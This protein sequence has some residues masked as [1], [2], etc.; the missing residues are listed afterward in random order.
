MLSLDNQVALVT[1]GGQGLGKEICKVLA[2]AGARV[3]VADIK[4][5]PAKKLA[6]ELNSSGKKAKAV[7]L[8]VSN[9]DNIKAAVDEIT[10]EFG[11]ID[12][13]I[14]NA[15]VDVTKPFVD[16]SVDE[17]QKVIGVNLS[18]P[19]L[20][21][22]AVFPLMEKQGSGQIVN[23]VSTAA[24]RAWTEASAY[25]A[26]KW[27]LLGFSHALHTEGRRVNIKVSAV[28]AGGMKTPFILDRFPEA[29]PNL[30]DPKNV[31]EAVLFVLTRPQESVIPEL[32]VLPMKETSW[33]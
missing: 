19:F 2:E 29:E 23:I 12:I 31:A 20:M 6:D 17:W 33:P 1:G 30:Q 4:E 9:P 14:N 10:Q 16:L 24:K 18:G 28:V 32:M 11:K 25:H 22:K 7:L 26:S 27:G 15:G 8:D 5:E 13:L 3:V 21:A